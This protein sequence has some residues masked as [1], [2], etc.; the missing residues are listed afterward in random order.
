MPGHRHIFQAELPP[1]EIQSLFQVASHHVQTG[2][3]FV[4]LHTASTY[5]LQLAILHHLADFCPSVVGLGRQPAGEIVS[6]TPGEAQRGVFGEQ[7]DKVIK[8]VL[9]FDIVVVLGKRYV[10]IF[11]PP[12]ISVAVGHHKD[13]C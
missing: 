4:M 5:K 13:L 6:F 9:D 3:S 12:G 8:D 11:N 2:Q 10:W 7:P 1:Q